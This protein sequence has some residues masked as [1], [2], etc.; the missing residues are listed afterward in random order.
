MHPVAYLGHF[1]EYAL[2]TGVGGQ[3]PDL[4]RPDKFRAWSGSN[5]FDT[6]KVFLK[7]FFRKKLFWKK[8]VDDKKALKKS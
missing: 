5:L 2:Y 4:I 1:T 7:D 3:S 6:Q 8:S